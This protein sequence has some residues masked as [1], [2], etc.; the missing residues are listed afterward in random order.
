MNR[1]Y[2]SNLLRGKTGRPSF[3]ATDNVANPHAPKMVGS[4]DGRALYDLSLFRK[5]AGLDG[6]LTYLPDEPTIL[7]F[8]HLLDAVVSLRTFLRSSMTD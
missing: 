5:F 2:F 1:R 6:G 7:R 3:S 8:R 4:G